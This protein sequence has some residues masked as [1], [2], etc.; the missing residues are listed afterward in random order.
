MINDARVM[1]KN[2]GEL[3][4]NFEVRYIDQIV[5]AAK[6]HTHLGCQFDHLSPA[7]ENLLQ[8]YITQV[9]REERA[10]LGI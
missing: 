6:K 1:L 8:K 3:K 4:V 2:F 10:R 5:R 9:Q 7:Q